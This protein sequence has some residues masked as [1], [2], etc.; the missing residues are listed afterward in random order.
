[1]V[2]RGTR[3]A[4]QLQAATF[5]PVRDVAL[6]LGES[7]AGSAARVGK[8]PRSPLFETWVRLAVWIAIGLVIYF[9]YG[10]HHSK[11]GRAEAGA[12]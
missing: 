2:A 8:R 9:A 7:R 12:R 6:D 5:D 3:R 11:V 10:R 1:V 4:I